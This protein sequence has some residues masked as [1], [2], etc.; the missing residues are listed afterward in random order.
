MRGPK[1]GVGRRF[2]SSERE[3]SALGEGRREWG[4]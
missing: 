4:K 2:F 3:F 1:G